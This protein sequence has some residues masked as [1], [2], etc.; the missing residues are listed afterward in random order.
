MS[1]RVTCR[2]DVHTPEGQFLVYIAAAPTWFKQTK[3]PSYTLF[4]GV[5]F[6]NLGF[7]LFAD[8]LSLLTFTILVCYGRDCA[9]FSQIQA[10][11]YSTL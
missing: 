6:K 1:R 5:H 10:C 2:A 4:H 8:V 7:I 9:S 3:L 11:V